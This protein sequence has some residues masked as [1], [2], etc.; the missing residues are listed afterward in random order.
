MSFFT[1]EAIN[2]VN[3]KKGSSITKT[4][5]RANF[6]PCLHVVLVYT[7][8]N[9]IIVPLENSVSVYCSRLNIQHICEQRFFRLLIFPSMSSD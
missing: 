7:Y 4:K 5:L 8:K 1:H 2:S 6:V 3:H 9:T